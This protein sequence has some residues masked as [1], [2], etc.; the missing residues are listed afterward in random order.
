MSNFNRL[1][2]EYEKYVRQSQDRKHQVD[3]HLQDRP[4]GHS[5]QRDRKIACCGKVYWICRR[6]NECVL[7]TITS[8]ERTLFR[9]KAL[10]QYAIGF[11]SVSSP[12]KNNCAKCCSF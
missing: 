11:K 12:S 3:T 8:P 5:P 9:M 1:G 7:N 2:A 4:I 6:K 10:T